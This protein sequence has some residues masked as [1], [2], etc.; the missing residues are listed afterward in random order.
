MLGKK[1]SLKEL[2]SALKSH[3][4]CVYARDYN[5]SHLMIRLPSGSS[6]DHY[7]VCAG[8]VVEVGHCM[9]I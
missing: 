9:V 7:R 8:E 4:V 2:V 1:A 6:G 3:Q 5:E